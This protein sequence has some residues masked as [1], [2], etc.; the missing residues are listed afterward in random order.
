[1][2]V[3]VGEIAKLDLL[4]GGKIYPPVFQLIAQ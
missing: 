2:F 1:M 4:N 3:V